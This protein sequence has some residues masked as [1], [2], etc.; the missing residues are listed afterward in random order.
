MT[1]QDRKCGKAFTIRYR[2]GN[3]QAWCVRLLV[4]NRECPLCRCPDHG[5]PC[6]EHKVRP[7]PR[8]NRAFLHYVE[9]SSLQ[10]L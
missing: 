2:G 1:V 7:N 6:Q 5:G 4:L 3:S 8:F 10:L 9:T